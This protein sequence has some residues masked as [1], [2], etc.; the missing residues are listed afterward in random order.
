MIPQFVP[1]LSH[2]TLK[3]KMEFEQII[4]QNTPQKQIEYV[5]CENIYYSSNILITGNFEAV[6]SHR[7]CEPLQTYIQCPGGKI[8][9]NETPIEAAQRETLQE[10]SLNI[11]KNRIKYIQTF[12]YG[13]SPFGPFKT[14]SKRH[15]YTFYTIITKEEYE[16]VKNNEPEKS[17]HW[18]KLKVDYI[19]ENYKNY[20]RYIDAL[21]DGLFNLPLIVVNLWNTVIEYKGKTLHYNGQA[22]RFLREIHDRMYNFHERMKNIEERKYIHGFVA[23]RN[24]FENLIVSHTLEADNVFNLQNITKFEP[25]SKDYPFEDVIVPYLEWEPVTA[26]RF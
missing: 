10:T 7:L 2:P 26:S 20:N 6:V 9:E 25:I 8:E 24:E 18:Y 16:E 4:S 3:F 23:Y 12:E 17:S 14:L 13:P 15:V 19:L 11:D 1:Y 5:R 22:Y 21:T